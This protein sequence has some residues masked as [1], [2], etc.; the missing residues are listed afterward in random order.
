MC[1]DDLQLISANS[2][3]CHSAA[4]MVQQRPAVPRCQVDYCV[5][6]RHVVISR[7]VVHFINMYPNLHFAYPNHQHQL[8]TYSH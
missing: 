3:L 5:S 6:M 7:V 1:L 8:A 4:A 2:D